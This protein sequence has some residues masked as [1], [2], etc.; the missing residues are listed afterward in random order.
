[1]RLRKKAHELKAIFLTVL[2]FSAG[3]SASANELEQIIVDTGAGDSVRIETTEPTRYTAFRLSSP[4]RLFVDMPGVDIGKIK[5]PII[6][7]NSYIKEIRITNYGMDNHKNIGRVE[8]GLKE[9]IDYVVKSGDKAIFI[10][11]KKEPSEESLSKEEKPA[12]VIV[13][14]ET[15]E[16]VA[17]KTA[18]KKEAPAPVVQ[19]TAVKEA[20]APVAAKTEA[21]EAVAPVVQKTA[22]K[23][24]PQPKAAVSLKNIEFKKEDKATVILL[25]ADGEI[26]NYNTFNLDDPSRLVLDIW[27][28]DNA[29]GN[30]LHS[31]SSEHIDTIRIGRHP[32]RIRL[33]FDF[34]GDKAPSFSIEKKG[35]TL[36]VNFTEAVKTGAAKTEAVKTGV[37]KTEAVK[38]G[39]AKT[40]A[41]KTEAVK[42]EAVKTGV[43]KTEAVKTGVAKTEAVKT[44]AVKAAVEAP[45]QVKEVVVA[46]E[47]TAKPVQI[48]AKAVEPVLPKVED[49]PVLSAVMPSAIIEAVDFKKTDNM[50]RLIVK[51]SA[52]PDYTVKKSLDGKVVTLDINDTV[53]PQ[54]LTRTL[55]AA[56][57]GTQVVSISSY[58]AANLPKKTARVLI[59]L[60]EESPY[61]VKEEGNSINIEFP[62]AVPA[63]LA[64][65]TPALSH[66]P[67]TLET[68]T[69]SQDAPVQYNGAL[70]DLDMVDAEISDIL[71][72]IA[73][74]SNLNI[75]VADD[76]KGKI[77]MR[78]KRVPWDQAFDIIL[79]TKGLDRIQ[80]GNVVRVNMADKIQQEKEKH[81][82]S[83]KAR[84]KVEPLELKYIQVNYEK[85]KDLEP[86]VAKVLSDRGSVSSHETTNTLIVKDI[87][88]RVGEAEDVVKS[89]D[90][91][92]PQVLIEARIVEAQSSFARDLGVQW[93]VDYLAEW[94]DTHTNVFGSSDQYGQAAYDP[95]VQDA[96]SDGGGVQDKEKKDW[97]VK[98]GVT[99]YAVNLPASGSV[100]TLGALGF[101]L[102]T[103]G[104][105]PFILDLRLSAG[106]QA[107]LLKTISRPRI[108]TLNNKEAKIE[109]GESIPFYNTSSSG[110][111]TIFKD[112]NLSLTVTPQITPDGSVLMKIKASR[113]S[114]GSFRTSSGLPSINK[115]EATTDVLVKDGET[116]VIGG[117]VISDSRETDQGIPY[118]KDIPGLGWLF[119]SKSVSDIQTEL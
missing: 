117:I 49:K 14:K 94:R 6:V 104:A 118:L 74:V 70:I 112:A 87:P 78:L 17:T 51:V 32:N 109:Q 47:I 16:P 55:D 27:D 102:G 31:I 106:E 21:K 80:E 24:A 30:Y 36:V 38:T 92:V 45:K 43:A 19:K 39:V 67:D 5:S 82:A 101:I 108:T 73:E 95:G 66:L 77:T 3:A 60:K 96:I 22:V 41:V 54:E 53:V 83:L 81:S 58:Q 7:D 76:V 29:T 9:D 35:D 93:G 63:P 37:A 114:I 56:Q 69:D 18:V 64:M 79:K 116:T 1:M 72:L 44:E 88:A 113:N 25:K 59:R 86:H 65:A 90:K 105:N 107:G 34:V 48:K 23:E 99:N 85:A 11:L 8:I 13:I 10:S 110:T 61:E 26:G 97:P 71:K 68:K 15:A 111:D 40:E 75:I 46:K 89:L 115:K 33:V 62:L 100:G 98:S 50:A 4:S 42:T 12:P 91:A 52:R 84:E 119:K 103:A 20:P 28:I 2:F 57:L